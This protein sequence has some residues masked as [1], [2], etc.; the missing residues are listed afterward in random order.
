MVQTKSKPKTTKAHSLD[1]FIATPMYGGM[2]YGTYTQS[3]ANLVGVFMSAGVES[4]YG[5]TLSE[6]LI[7][8]ARDYLADEFMQS[9]CSHLMF[10]DADIG[11]NARDILSMVVADK[12]IICGMYPRKEIEWGRVAHAVREGVPANELH[13]YSSG[14]FPASTLD[15]LNVSKAMESLDPQKPVEVRNAATGF[16]LIK[17]EVLDGLADKVPQYYPIAQDGHKASRAR[18]QYF[19]TSIDPIE[20]TLLH[21]DYSFCKLARDN[22]FKVWVAPWVELTHTGTQTYTGRLY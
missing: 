22:G 10:I 1:I 20:Q 5:T 6:S 16:M 14:S 11:F 8:K 9:G 19:N 2:S 7:T 3:L 4:T 17:R 15:G 21:E 12:D 13:M 18:K